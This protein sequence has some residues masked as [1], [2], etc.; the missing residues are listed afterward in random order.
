MR[1]GETKREAGVDNEREIRYD[2]IK[3]EI[4]TESPHNNRI[5]PCQTLATSILRKQ[6]LINPDRTKL[7]KRIRTGVTR[8]VVHCHHH[9]FPSPQSTIPSR[10]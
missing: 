7:N 3:S 6:K 5:T 1:R 2:R 4:Y 9:R 10:V 8:C